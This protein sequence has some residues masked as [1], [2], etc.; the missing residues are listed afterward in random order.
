LLQTL[1][2]A[3][4]PEIK[5]FLI[6][7]IQL[8]S[9]QEAVPALAALLPDARLCTPA[10]EALVVIGGTSAGEALRLAKP[11]NPDA[12]ITA[13]GELEYKPAAPEL[14][15]L[16]ETN[17]LARYALARMGDEAV[18]PV[19][20]QQRDLP[21]LMRIARK[22]K[23]AD[24]CNAILTGP[25]APS[26]S[27]YSDALY[28]L[29]E[30]AGTSALPE[31][32]TAMRSP[33]R[34]VRISAVRLL[35]WMRAA[36]SL[37]G[38]VQDPDASARIVA[39]N[40]LVTLRDKEARALC[41]AALAETDGIVRAAAIRGL[42]ALRDRESVVALLEFLPR[43]GKDEVQDLRRALSAAP[44][45]DVCPYLKTKWASADASL[46]VT[47]LRVVAPLCGKMGEEI[48]WRATGDPDESVRLEAV[49]VIGQSETVALARL[50]ELV[51]RARTDREA[52]KARQMFARAGREKNPAEVEAVILAGMNAATPRERV[53]LVGLLP[54]VGGKNSVA[55]LLRESRATDEAWRDAAIRVLAEWRDVNAVDALVTVSREATSERHRILAS[56]GA[57]RLAEQWNGSSAEK[58]TMWHR[59][60]DTA[61]R[62]EEKQQAQAALQKLETKE[63]P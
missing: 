57:I 44:T 25:P 19:L 3:A 32:Q 21:N 4:D 47:L 24:L 2:T 61:P 18:I 10:A 59:I 11:A 36:P 16:M 49:E 22:L 6:E 50:L 8:V 26:A 38:A 30:I 42:G 33:D 28:M 31:V 14:R 34:S 56:R 15:P 1:A 46:K 55:M 43:A 27:E 37:R 5:A 40:S 63:I 60:L 41:M 51:R 45:A 12:V 35:A 52:Q 54:A 13:L 48:V 62:E 53:Q 58:I 29:C 9:R 20:Q 17:A 7:E 39:L 23:R